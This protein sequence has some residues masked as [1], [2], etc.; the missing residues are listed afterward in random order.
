[1][2]I[3]IAGLGTV[4]TF[5]LETFSACHDCRVYDPPRGLGSR[6][7]LRDVDFVLVCVPTPGL[8]DGTYDL[9]ILEEVVSSAR[10][11]RAV[12]VHSTVPVGTTDRLAATHDAPVVFVPE[13]IGERADHPY[14]DRTRR[15]FFIFGGATEPATHAADLFRSVYGRDVAMHVVP[16]RVA[17]MVKA[18]ENAFLATKVGFCNDFHDLCAATGISF[19]ELRRLW[20]LDDRVGESHTV[21]TPERGFGGK[22]LPKDVA[23]TCAYARAVGAPLE[24][25][26]AVLRSNTRRRSRS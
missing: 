25:L 18:M 19:E 10:V 13:Y 7:D 11:R 15:R 16:A 12:I 24:V 17:E 23:A 5:A 21:V 8:A 20:L 2:K 9:R 6:A 26:E 14:R 1:M 3:T 22:C 4:G